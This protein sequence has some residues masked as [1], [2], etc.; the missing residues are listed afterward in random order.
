[1]Q[2]DEEETKG[3]TPPELLE[4]IR[5][6]E[7]STRHGRNPTNSFRDRRRTQE[8]RDRNH[9]DLTLGERTSLIDLL[10]EYKDIF[11]WSYDD[12][13]ELSTDIVQHKIPL[14]SDAKPV[15]QKLRRIR[16]E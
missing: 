7:G 10:K 12:I 6:K 16:P 8:V 1:M 9:L 5:G 3:E 11:T 2:V 14:Y 15:K 13:P 4:M